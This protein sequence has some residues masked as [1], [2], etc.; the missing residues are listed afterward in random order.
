[1]HDWEGKSL[2][3][4]D[5][6]FAQREGDGQRAGTWDVYMLKCPYDVLSQWASNAEWHAGYL[7][8]EENPYEEGE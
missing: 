2:P 8:A 6:Y 1:M 3:W 4:Q 7:F 5:G